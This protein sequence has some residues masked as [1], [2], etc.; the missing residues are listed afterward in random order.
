MARQ[1]A[2]EFPGDPTALVLALDRRVREQWGDFESFPLSIISREDLLVTVSAPYLSFRTSLMDVLR[3]GQPIERAVWTGTIVVAV[4]PRRLEAADIES[5][6]VSRDGRLVPPVS[7]TLRP[8][9]FSNGAGRE[10]V[11]HAGDVH[12]GV[13]AFS[14]GSRVVLRLAPRGLDPILYAFSAEELAALR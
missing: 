10:G 4:A 2:R 1:A 6:S 9:A 12:F 3:T 8:M 7:A 11:L 14:P 13:S 5:V